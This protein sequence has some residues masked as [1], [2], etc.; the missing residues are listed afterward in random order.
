MYWGL[1]FTNQR[2]TLAYLH[3]TL[4]PL[5]VMVGHYL[6]Q[7]NKHIMICT[8]YVDRTQK[9]TKRNL[10]EGLVFTHG[11][12]SCL[13]IAVNIIMPHGSYTLWSNHCMAFPHSLIPWLHNTPYPEA[14]IGELLM[15]IAVNVIMPQGSLYLVVK[16]MYGFRTFSDP[17]IT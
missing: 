5:S 6:F 2:M 13:C 8:Y 14:H 4:H 16:S 1:T 9:K 7:I 11:L 12:G 10:S 17:M 15:Y 3:H